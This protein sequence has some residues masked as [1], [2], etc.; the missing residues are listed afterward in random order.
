MA[1]KLEEHLYRSALTREDYIEPASLKRRLHVIAKGVGIPKPGD[2]DSTGEYDESLVRAAVPIEAVSQG[3]APDVGGSSAT[4]ESLTNPLSQRTNQQTQGPP[5]QVLLQQQQQQL[6]QQPQIPKAPQANIAISPGIPQEITATTATQQNNHGNSNNNQ[7]G[8]DKKNV[9]LLQ[10][11]RRLLLLRHASKCNK[12]TTCHVKFCS[13]M[14]TLWKHMKKCRDKNCKI[15]H[16]LSSRCVLNHYRLCKAEGRTPTCAICAPVMKHIKQTGGDCSVPFGGADDLD[17]N[18]VGSA[19]TQ[20]DGG[21]GT[22]NGMGEAGAGGQGLAISLAPNAA[23]INASA[24]QQP[25][26][27]MVAAVTPQHIPG[28][29]QGLQQEL[30]KKQLLLQHILQQKVNRMTL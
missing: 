16:C 8:S 23:P 6:Q 26:P 30:Q 27:A 24:P 21:N 25:Q 2:D 18:S 22:A 13:Q 12:G 15:S 7:G 9:I 28:S 10:Q 20:A 29:I 3:P 5:Q 14:V 19:C 17:L 1:K 11:Q 4:I